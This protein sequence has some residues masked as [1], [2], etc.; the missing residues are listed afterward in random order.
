MV[1]V[2]EQA[3][4][5]TNRSLFAHGVQLS[6]SEIQR[7][8]AAQAAIAFCPSSNLFLGSGLFPL[9]QALETNSNL[10]LGLG[11]DIGAGTSFS[12]LRTAGDAYKVA[13]L[14]GQT[15][16]PLQAFFLATLGGARALNLDHLLGNFEVGKEADVVVLNPRATPLMAFR[17]AE[18]PQ[19]LEALSDCLFSLMIM[20][21][22]RAVE[23]TY[24]MG[25]RI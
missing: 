3:G 2:Y 4:L 7:L 6:T 1:Q 11:T 13:Q 24:V 12:L 19:T 18:W 5:V 15:V 25:Q 9:H 23:A 21:D 10:K 17:N 20:G 8:A 16:S 14:Q 22:D